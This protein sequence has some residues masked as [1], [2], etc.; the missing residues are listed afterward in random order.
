MDAQIGQNP[1]SNP[2]GHP[3]KAI[4]TDGHMVPVDAT[5]T[6]T[7]E[8]NHMATRPPDLLSYDALPLTDTD[9]ARVQVVLEEAAF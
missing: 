7:W 3:A 6:F 8:D 4:T 9:I 2:Y 5:S 1:W